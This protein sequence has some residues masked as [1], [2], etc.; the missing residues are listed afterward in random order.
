MASSAASRPD[1]GALV[2]AA[3][4]LLLSAL[5]WYWQV[6]QAE[7]VAAMGD[8]RM[9]PTRWLSR[10]GLL[11]LLMW[12]VMMQAMMLPA[13]LPMIM[14]YRRCLQRDR[15]RVAK[16]WLFCAAY[17]LMWCG[18][19]LL[20]TGLQALGERAGVLEP[21]NLRL[22][23]TLGGLMLLVAGLYQLSRAKAACLEHCQ[24]PLQFLQHHA[25]PGLSGAWLTGLH[26]GLY[27]LGCCWALMLILLVLGAMSLWGMAL[28]SLLVLA[29]KLL[30][31]GAGWR[32]VSG[33]LLIGS[34]V[35]L[36]VQA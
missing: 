11:A 34:G 28:L 16:L 3:S 14:L 13:A 35:W 27:C 6:R 7:L 21:M 20:L 22:P 30:P 23:P 10:E 26:H 36:L 24:S 9:P 32:R 4:V 18:F 15:R 31:L 5:A 1:W 25:R 8:M 17:G 2:A 19:A 29:E 12:L 33:A